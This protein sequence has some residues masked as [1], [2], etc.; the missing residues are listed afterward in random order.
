VETEGELLMEAN[1]KLGRIWGIPVGLHISWF[2]IFALV[3]YS[4]AVSYFPAEYPVLSPVQH[5]LL[6]ALTSLLF[7]GSVLVHELGHSF[8]ALRNGIPVRAITLFIFGGVAQIGK[9]PKSAG[10][11][12]IIAI[13]G[14]LS[15]LGLAI[16][17][18]GL[19]LLD[20]AFPI[21]AAPSLWLMRI[22]LMLAIFNL[23]PGFPL[24][25]GRV[26]RAVVWKATGDFH[27]AT[28]VASLAGQLVAF[29]FIGW[30]ILTIL[31]GNFINGVWLTFIGWF[32]QNASA[33]SS[34]QSNIQQALRGVKVSQ[35]MATDCLQIP[36]GLSLNQLV[37]EKILAGGQRCFSVVESG[38]LQGM[39]TLHQVAKVP[40]IDWNR[41]TT[42]QAMTPL[43]QLVRVDPQTELLTALQM[44]DNAN[45]AQVPV[46]EGDKIVGLLSREHILHYVRIKAELGV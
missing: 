38:Q 43:D 40:K 41:I 37:E 15:S 18:G 44:M 22:N 21:F 3:T 45:V 14:P 36:P 28:Q 10:A 19:W 17:F 9:E 7:F 11:E 35:V 25:G 1:I 2:L 24:D 34:E 31:S 20:R 8:F 32:L 46:T 27:R 5:W 13:A 42:E 16:V 23:I 39:I 29:G 12:F 33:A 30:G 26:L 4:L 6:G